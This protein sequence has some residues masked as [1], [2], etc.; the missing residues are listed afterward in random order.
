MRSLQRAE[1]ALP[2]SPSKQKAVVTSLAKKFNLGIM[3]QQQNRGRKREELNDEESSWLVEFLEL[4][5]ITCDTRQVR[6]NIYGKM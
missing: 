2:K 3:Q 4:L 5:D 1:K 6:P